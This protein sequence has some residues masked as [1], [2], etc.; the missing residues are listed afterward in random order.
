MPR[1]M[2]ISDENP[3]QNLGKV[4]IDRKKLVCRPARSRKKVGEKHFTGGRFQLFYKS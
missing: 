4:E 2:S 1:Y 3:L